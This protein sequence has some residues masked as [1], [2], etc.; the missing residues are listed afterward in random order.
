MKKISKRLQHLINLKLDK[1]YSIDSA[2][3]LV[4]QFGTA[5]FVESIEAHFALN[6]NPK[7]ANQQL[8]SNLI[9]PYPSGKEIKIAIYTNEQNIEEYLKLGASYVGYESL[10]SEIYNGHINFDLLITTPNL[11][12]ELGKVGRILGP[13][14]L[15]PSPKAGTVVNNI[16]ET[17]KDFKSGKFEYRA[18]KTGVVHLQFGKTNFPEFQ[19]KEN[20]YTIYNSI[21]KNKPSGI[22]GKYFK[23]INLCTTMSPSLLIDLNSLKKK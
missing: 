2:I 4:K 12:A 11:I 13:K 18:D 20:L 7:Y 9:L 22:K 21:E 10:L 23:S 3:E 19:L 1:I 5:K 8:R 16:T 17:I 14:G 6:I 15:M